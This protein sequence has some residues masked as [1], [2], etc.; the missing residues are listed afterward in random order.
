MTIEIAVDGGRE[1]AVRSGM[2]VDF[3]TPLYNTS[4]QQSSYR[5]EITQALSVHPKEIFTYITKNTGDYIQKG[6]IIAQKKS[7]FHTKTITA[8]HAG[9]LTEIDHIDGVVLIEANEAEHASETCWFA[10]EIVSIAKGH[11]T[12]KVGKHHSIPAEHISDQFGG[13]L[14]FP[15]DELSELPAF[16]VACCERLNSYEKAKMEAMGVRGLI[17]VTPYEGDISFPVAKIK[18][19]AFLN[20]V[21]A[22]KLSYCVTQ[23]HRSTIIFYSV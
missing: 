19:G 16:P 18:D 7:F 10:G 22:K 13:E 4:E 20:E 23:A 21:R 3:S 12:L 5:V 1:L 2:K 14:W 15:Q 8:E 11:I 9:I 17:I 6:E